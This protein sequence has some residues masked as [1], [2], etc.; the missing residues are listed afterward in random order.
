MTAK[1]VD[2]RQV[3]KAARAK[4]FAST[5]TEELVS[6][7]VKLSAIAK[8]SPEERLT[9]AWTRDEIENRIPA[10][11]VALQGAFDDAFAKEERGGECIEVD[12]TAV[13]LSAIEASK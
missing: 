11:A 13:I 12:P 5:S 9:L 4:I 10:V 2:G 8:P 6:A 7:M 1:Y 3:G